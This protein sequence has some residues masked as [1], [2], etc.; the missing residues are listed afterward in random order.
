VRC[1]S[2]NQDHLNWELIFQ[3]GARQPGAHSSECEE[4]SGVVGA[5]VQ[6]RVA[7]GEVAGATS[8]H[9]RSVVECRAFG[10]L[11]ERLTD[12]L[13]MPFGLTISTSSRREVND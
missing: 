7:L 6:G 4:K 13:A 2:R 8:I 5:S 10:A 9:A 3:P 1:R 11:Y 12:P